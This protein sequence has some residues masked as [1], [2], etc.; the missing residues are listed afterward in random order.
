MRYVSRLILTEEEA[1]DNI[2]DYE[3]SVRDWVKQRHEDPRPA[4]W[5]ILTDQEKIY[6]MYFEGFWFVDQNA[7]IDVVDV[8]R[9]VEIV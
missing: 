3:V 8:L 7:G 6:F 2:H 5:N 1:K 9:S 4:Q